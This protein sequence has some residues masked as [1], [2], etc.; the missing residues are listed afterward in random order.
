M[1][2]TGGEGAAERRQASEL[3]SNP[4]LSSLVLLKEHPALL[5]KNKFMDKMMMSGRA[6]MEEMPRKQSCLQQRW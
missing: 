1:P 5:K 4:D 6:D 3:P 2:V